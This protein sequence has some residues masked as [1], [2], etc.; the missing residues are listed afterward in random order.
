[1]GIEIQRPSEQIKFPA[2]KQSPNHKKGITK[3][4]LR[5]EQSLYNDI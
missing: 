1:M 5:M 4:Q 3:L 2:K